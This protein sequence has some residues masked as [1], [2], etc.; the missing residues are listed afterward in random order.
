MKQSGWLQ[1]KEDIAGNPY[2]VCCDILD[3]DIKSAATGCQYWIIIQHVGHPY[4]LTGRT[5]LLYVNMTV[6]E[7]PLL[8]VDITDGKEFKNSCKLLTTA[9]G[10][11]TLTVPHTPATPSSCLKSLNCTSHSSVS[12]NTTPYCRCSFASLKPKQLQP[13]QP[14]S[15]T[16]LQDA[17]D[18]LNYSNHCAFTALYCFPSAPAAAAPTPLPLLLVHN[19]VLLL[20]I[21]CNAFAT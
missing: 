7:C 14:P 5:F 2:Q 15:L 16:S 3:P 10:R 8:P 9:H 20:L 6:V 19:P 1:F 4:D 21:P 18:R 12:R 17:A 13:L 11:A